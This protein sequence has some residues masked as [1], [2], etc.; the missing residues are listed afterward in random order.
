MENSHPAIITPE[1]FDF[2]QSEFQKRCMKP[3]S[4]TSIYATK[5]ICGDCG[6]Y[7]GAKVWHSNS[8]YRRVIYQC[9]SKFKGSHFCTTPHLYEPEIQEKFL[10]AFAQYFSQKDAVIKNCQFALTRLKK[11]ESR[12]AELQDELVA[13][14]EK[15]KDY[16][17]HGG[18]DF[19]ALNAKYEELSAKLDAE[20]TAE[21]DRK[22]RIAKM[23][24]ILLMLKKTDSVLE[25]FD[26]SVWNAV[27]E[28]LTVFHDGSLVFLFR[29]GMEVKV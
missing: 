21:S 26:E 15:L 23:Q 5:I 11:Q 18:E 7:F 24:K 2:V 10:Q 1:E 20:E 14:N 16:I 4:S 28:N 8:K 13:V 17:Q 19:D 29:D 27:L 22:R 12:K 3:Y 25:T 9:N 6:S